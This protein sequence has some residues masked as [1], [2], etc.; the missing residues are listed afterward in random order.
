MDSLAKSSL[1]EW[2]DYGIPID[3]TKYTV[4]SDRYQATQRRPEEEV[5]KERLMSDEHGKFHMITHKGNRT[6]CKRI[7]PVEAID[8]LNRNRFELEG[9][10]L[11]YV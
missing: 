1:S 7:A 5:I 8:W 4:V 3:E 10:D 11:A 9:D 6:Y 2:M